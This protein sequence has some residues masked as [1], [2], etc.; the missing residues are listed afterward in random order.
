MKV[1]PWAFTSRHGYATKARRD[2]RAAAEYPSLPC[3][4]KR[5]QFESSIWLRP[6]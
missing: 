2:P 1:R 6:L 5:K 3:S 4:A